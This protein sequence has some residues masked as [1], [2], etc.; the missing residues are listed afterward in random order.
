MAADWDLSAVCSAFSE[1]SRQQGHSRRR[2]TSMF[3]TAGYYQEWLRP[4][5]LKWFAAVRVAAGGEHWALSIQRTESRGPFDMRGPR[6]CARGLRD[7]PQAAAVLDKRSTV[8]LANR[9]ADRIS[10]PGGTASVAR[11]RSAA[12]GTNATTELRNSKVC[13]SGVIRSRRMA[14]GTK[15]MSAIDERTVTCGRARHLPIVNALRTSK[16]DVLSLVGIPELSVTPTD[17]PSKGETCDGHTE[18][19]RGRCLLGERPIERS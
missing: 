11:L 7:I 12:S 14:T 13:A 3:A 10:R 8:V 5:G 15:T 17:C 6:R 9:A 1:A 4:F 16:L 19:E 18:I 2:S